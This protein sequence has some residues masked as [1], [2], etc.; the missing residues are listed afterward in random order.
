MNTFTNLRD[1]NYT[2]AGNNFTFD[3]HS[4]TCAGHQKNTTGFDYFLVVGRKIHLDKRKN[5]PVYDKYTYGNIVY[6]GNETYKGIIK[7]I[8]SG[9]YDLHVY[10]LI[11]G[12]LLGKYYSNTFFSQETSPEFSRV[13]AV[14]NFTWIYG[15]TSSAVEFYPGVH[16]EGCIM[17]KY[18]EWHSFWIRA[19][20]CIRFWI[21]GVLVLDFWDRNLG[22]TK[23]HTS[24]YLNAYTFHEIVLEHRE[25][26]G[27][28]F[29]QLLWS[30]KNNPLQVIPSNSLFKKVHYASL[31]FMKIFFGMT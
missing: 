10:Q 2:L 18:S 29:I 14:I 19:N 9:L 4:Q 6:N 20:G 30:S 31:C 24:H 23:V 5:P 16:W 15:S 22:E 7:G 3:I 1:D 8:E 12:G 17:S 13:D 28:G 27:G 25:F 11:P 26:S 21:D